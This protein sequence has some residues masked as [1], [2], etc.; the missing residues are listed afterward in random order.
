MDDAGLVGGG[1]G[2]AITATTEGQADRLG[3][4]VLMKLGIVSGTVPAAGVTPS[5]LVVAASVDQRRLSAETIQAVALEIAIVENNAA[6]EV[7]I[8]AAAGV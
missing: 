3:Y 5:A 6:I 1:S 2:G 7:A 8:N 4:G